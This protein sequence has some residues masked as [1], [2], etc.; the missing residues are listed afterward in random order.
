MSSSIVSNAFAKRKT[1]HLEIHGRSIMNKKT[2]EALGLAVGLFI[3]FVL[4]SLIGAIFTLAAETRNV[5]DDPSILKILDIVAPPIG[6]AMILG[7]GFLFIPIVVFWRTRH[8]N[9][10][11]NGG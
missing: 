5:I 3:L 9:G 10:A 7:S 11:T 4:A 8:Q 2:R 6:G 1:G